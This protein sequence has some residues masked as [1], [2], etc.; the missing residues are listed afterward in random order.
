MS[1]A[2]HLIIPYAHAPG[3]AVG[4]GTAAGE[5][6]TLRRLLTRLQAGPLLAGEAQDLS[7]PHERAL[8]QALG[9]PLPMA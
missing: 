8:A 7:P 5:L 4:P 9:C 3:L 1:N 2:Q 6:P